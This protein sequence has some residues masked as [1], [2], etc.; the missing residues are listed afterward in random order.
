MNSLGIRVAVVNAFDSWLLAPYDY[1]RLSQ[2]IGHLPEQK[3][4]SLA[5]KT[6]TAVASC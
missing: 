5:N 4:D 1:G 3:A 2:C 6:L